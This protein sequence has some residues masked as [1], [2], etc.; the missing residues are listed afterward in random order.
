MRKPADTISSHSSPKTVL[1]EKHDV[2]W[3]MSTCEVLE[4]CTYLSYSFRESQGVYLTM[5]N[6][7]RKWAVEWNWQ[8]MGGVS[9]SDAM[10]KKECVHAKK[11]A[12]K[13][14]NLLVPQV[15]GINLHFRTDPQL[16]RREAKTIRL[17]ASIPHRVA[18]KSDKV[19][20]MHGQL[21]SY[22]G[23]VIS[24]VVLSYSRLPYYLKVFVSS[25][26]APLEKD[27][28]LYRIMLH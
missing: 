19:S 25:R 14:S 16:S 3:Q 12:L 10:R 24:W 28:R 27:V 4:T 20:I 8:R 2:R 26:A 18:R 5:M 17:T 11:L 23:L 9:S 15:Q 6:S 13:R 22:Y 21:V 7:C 1:I